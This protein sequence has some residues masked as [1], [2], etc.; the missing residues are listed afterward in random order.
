MRLNHGRRVDPR[1]RREH[2]HG[3]V[4]VKFA[5]LL[6]PLL[7]MSGLSVDVGFWYSRASDI[8]KAADAAALAGVIWL[9]DEGAAR[10]HALEAAARNGFVDGVN[11][12]TVSVERAGDR[13]LRVTIA[14][15]SVGS[16]LWQNLGGREIDLARDGL[17]E[18]VMPVPL[19]SPRNYFGTG[20]LLGESQQEFLYQSV[21]ASCTSKVQ[22]DRNQSLHFRP[23]QLDRNGKETSL[24]SGCSRT[25]SN[26]DYD[27]DGYDL[28]VEAPAG[29][30][31][32]IEVLLYDA[33]YSNVPVATGRQNCV[34]SPAWNPSATGWI[35]PGG[36]SNSVTV[37]G[38]AVYQTLSS[39]SWSGDNVLNPG[40]SYSHRQDRIRYRTVATTW[41]PSATGWTG[42]GAN[43]SVTVTGP[44]QYQL[45]A[46][47]TTTTWGSTVTLAPGDSYSHR[48]DRIR[49]R[50]ATTATTSACTPEQEP[51]I[52]N[53][54]NDTGSEDEDFTFTLYAADDTPLD[55]RDDVVVPGCQRVFTPTTPFDTRTFLGSVR[56]NRLCTITPQMADGR[57][58]L[59]VQNEGVSYTNLVEGSNQWGL[60]A[61]Y[62]N[63]SDDG[64]CD[65]RTV[66][67]CPRVYGRDAISV[68][69]NSQG[70]TASF[71]LAEIEPEHVGKTL[72]LELWDPGEGGESISFLEPT[73]ADSWRAV[74]VTWR[75]YEENGSTVANGSGTSIALRSGNE[76]RF[77]GRLL[78]IQIPLTSYNPPANNRWWKISYT[79][80]TGRSVTDRTT[81]SARVIGDPVHLLEDEAD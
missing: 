50:T 31:A 21:N 81:W 39:G 19:G 42:P 57:Y 76:D 23:L 11:D 14:D 38:M 12:V 46:N 65:G 2:E 48:G 4:L 69:A 35:G 25:P 7:L 20:T 52:D 27:A 18:Y 8:Q 70:A 63:A 61:R 29:R 5:L 1:P 60:V 64:L 16:F 9:P 58:L 74:N 26:P 37:N 75:S 55:D 40:Q 41:A 3:Y 43:T 6:V 33:R 13:R 67:L 56:W 36:N 66:P 72:E 17:A 51:S 34:S 44:A 80:A 71:F 30:T 73:G 78:R 22:G 79:F 10:S 68:Y 54:L 24:L 53:M 47:S 45:R 32:N 15:A 62:T 59:R 28:Y 77:N 49:Y